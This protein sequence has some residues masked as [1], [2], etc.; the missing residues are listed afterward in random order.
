VTHPVTLNKFNYSSIGSMFAA[1]IVTA[2]RVFH[3]VRDS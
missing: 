1:K 2:Q 3:Y